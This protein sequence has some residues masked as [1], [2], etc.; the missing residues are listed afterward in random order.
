MLLSPR[1][2]APGQGRDKAEPAQGSRTSS[3]NECWGSIN[4]EQPP[5]SSPAS[6]KTGDGDRDSRE[7]G[8]RAAQETLKLPLEDTRCSWIC[9]LCW[10]M[11]LLILSWNDSREIF[12]RFA[13][14]YS[15]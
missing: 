5:G 2:A 10:C 8:G 11:A 14:K 9:A 6:P 1:A 15:E 12:L 7:A 4:Q 3:T 13:P